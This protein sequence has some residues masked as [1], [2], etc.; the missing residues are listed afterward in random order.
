M[1]FDSLGRT[2]QSNRYG[3][4]ILAEE[5][6]S[7]SV[8]RLLDIFDTDEVEQKGSVVLNTLQQI[9]LEFGGTPSGFQTVKESGESG[10]R[11]FSCFPSAQGE[12][13]LEDLYFEIM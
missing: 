11:S 1:D 10:S 8:L 13:R 4:L 2:G 9:A 12:S 6:L 3:K 7:S 5:L